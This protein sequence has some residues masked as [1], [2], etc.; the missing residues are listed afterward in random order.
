MARSDDVIV[1][2]SLLQNFY[3]GDNVPPSQLASKYG[4]HVTG[5]APSWPTP[6]PGQAPE[7]LSF[8]QKA[9]ARTYAYAVAGETKSMSF[10]VTTAEFRLVYV[11]KTANP[12]IATEIFL[13][14]LWYPSGASVV[15]VASSGNMRVEYDA[16]NSNRV[17]VYPAAGVRE[18]SEV[19]VVVKRKGKATG[20]AITRSSP[21]HN[22]FA[23]EAYPVFWAVHGANASAFAAN[24]TIN[25]AQYGIKNDSFTVC[26]HAWLCHAHAVISWRSRD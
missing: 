20:A 7:P 17:L 15:A 5:N 10:S 12:A 16:G 4:A 26:A 11:V 24:G 21:P 22:P 14:K 13:S 6:P 1:L 8:F 2:L 25:I 19:T 23:I 3:R 18:D 9:Y